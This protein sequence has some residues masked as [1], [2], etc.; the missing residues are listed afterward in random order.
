VG[1]GLG[2]RDSLLDYSHR[3]VRIVTPKSTTSQPPSAARSTH[4]G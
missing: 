2:E 3:Q 4:S 1:E